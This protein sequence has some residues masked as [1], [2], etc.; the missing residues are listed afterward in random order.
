MDH[1][2][3]LRLAER[4]S[5]PPV[6]LVHG[7]AQLADD[8]LHLVGRR[9]FPD[10]AGAALDRDAFDGR[11]VGVETVVDAANTLPLAAPR[12]LVLVRHAQALPARGADVLSR[13]AAVPNPAACLLLLADDFLGPTRER[14]SPHWLLGAVPAG[15]VVEPVR[16]QGRAVVDWL[17][18]RAQ[19]EGLTVTEDAAKLLIQWVGEDAAALLGEARKAALAGGPDNWTVGDKEVAAVVG[20][21]RVSAVYELTRAIERRETGQALR[22]LERLLATEH[23]I[24]ILALLTR[25]VRTAWTIR[26]WHA[27]GLPVEQIARRL[28][29]PP[30]VVQAL[31]ASATAQSPPALAR[32]LRRCW[33]VEQRLKSSGEPGAEM[34]ALVTE[35]CRGA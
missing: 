31:V 5:L 16:R 14:K 30:A 12:R 23:P 4:G 8:V 25:E 20:E 18:Q 32:K 24:G 21:H 13:Y 9:L 1:A 2:A 35:L 34:A 19:A 15:G 27:A 10:G 33:E 28:G 26:E 3:L 29:R 17:R 22:T 7:D 11:E 6:I